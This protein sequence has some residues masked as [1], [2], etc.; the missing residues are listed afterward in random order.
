MCVLTLAL[1]IGVNTAIFSVVYGVLLRPLPYGEGQRLVVLQQQ[2]AGAG[3]AG[4]PFSAQEVTDYR[5]QNHSL[6]EVVEHHTMVFLLLGKDTAERVQTAVVSANFFEALGVKPLLGRTFVARDDAPDSDAVLV[7]SYKYWKERHGG[8]PEIV[9]RVFQMNNRPHTVVGVLPPI[10]QYPVENDVYMP[11]SHCPTRSSAAFISNRAARMMTVFGRLKHATPVETAQADLATVASRLE[12]AHPEAYPKNSGYG[13]AA[14]PLREKLTAAA[15]PTFLLLLGAA[16]LVLLIA[17]ANVANLLLSHVLTLEPELAV[18]TALGASRARLTRQLLAESLLLSLTGGALGVAVA[19]L[20]LNLLV[21]FAARF[22]TRAAEVRMDAPVLLFA[23]AL[24]VATGLLFGLAPT[25]SR[26]GRVAETINQTGRH[27]TAARERKRLRA[28]LVIAQAA[29][30]FVLLIG[31]G[32]MIRSL[33]KLR[34]VDPGFNPDRLLTLRMTPNFT[35]H[36]TALQIGALLERVL[37]KVRG[38]G[39]VESAALASNVPFSQAG[40]ASG[41]GSVAFAIEGRTESKGEAAPRVDVTAVSDG[42][43]ATIRQPLLRG[44]LFDERDGREAPPV[45]VVNETMAR[46]RWPAADP[47]GKRVTFDNGATWITVAGVVGDVKEYGLSHP[48]GDEI[49]LPIKQ[50]GFGGYLVV[51]T[52]TAPMSLAPLIRAALREVDP[53]IAVDRVAPVEHLAEE[54]VAT[55]RVMTVLLGLFALVATAISAGGIAA[56]IT[57][58]V[59]QRTHELGVRMALGASRESIVANVV[60]QGLWL[61]LGGVAFGVAG[62]LALTQILSSQLYGIGPTDILTFG[63]VSLLFVGVAAA[64]SAIPAWRV[65]GI[66]PVI[67]LRHE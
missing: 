42:Y 56:A 34:E 38:T 36:G 20:A 40:V 30:S 5:A 26:S 67:A 57:L 21:R 66:D 63:A 43:F 10:P 8:D 4:I 3:P 60:A 49:Y 33:L 13:I 53:Q 23:L 47:T 45:A 48:P 1:G 58:S 46:H 62:A 14:S 37:E 12:S 39:G 32:L 41:P 65:T 29:I 25:L 35:R 52:A 16:G 19:P 31:A 28:S 27:V 44:R 50:S 7:L 61:G 55:R 22:T 54:S 64:A 18:R 9:G 51:R 24:S 2:T 15:R 11:T 6:E 59:R 17:C